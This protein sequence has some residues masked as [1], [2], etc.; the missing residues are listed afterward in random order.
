MNKLFRLCLNK[1]CLL[2]LGLFCFFFMIPP[3]AGSD[4]GMRDLA[5]SD[6]VEDELAGDIW[7]PQ[8]QI[9]VVTQD[10]IVTLQGSVDHVLAKDRATRIA[11]MVRGVR[12]VVNQIKVSPSMAYDDKEI[13]TK[14]EAALKDD[15]A[16]EDLE[17]DVKVMDGTVLLSGEVDSQSE[18]I[19]AENVTKGVRGVKAVE[20]KIGLDVPYIS[21]RPDSEIRKDIEERLRWDVLVDHGQIDVD[22]NKGTVILSGT[23]G[24]AAEKTRAILDAQV[25]GMDRID[26]S[27]LKAEKWERD[28]AFRKDKYVVKTDEEIQKA[29]QDA[30]SYDPR[31]APFQGHVDVD[32]GMVTLRGQ[33]DNL[34]AKRA[35]TRDAMN[36]VGVIAVKNRL[37]VRPGEKLPDDT[38]TD[39]VRAALRRSPHVD[40]YD[41][42]VTNRQGVV[43]V[44][45]TVDTHAQRAVASDLASG[46]KGVLMVINHITVRD[47]MPLV[48]NPYLDD[49]YAYGYTD[50]EERKTLKSDEQ[51]KESVKRELWWSPF[52]DSDDINVTVEK[53]AVTLT[54]KVD[55]WPEYQ[56]AAENAFQ[57]GATWVYNLL[58]CE[59]C[60]EGPPSASYPLE[61]WMR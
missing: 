12:G 4:A 32:S 35:A 20:N 47:D 33:V 21:Q 14:V 43:T 24:S 29:V 61:R 16:A 56:I 17:I 55:S 22:V 57:G 42:D 11:E 10:G 31:V 26:A 19:L 13:L 34:K 30:F 27:G 15:P 2:L 39:K 60:V 36:T 1:T 49:W 58:A 48:Y 46:I 59:T 37:K 9:D 50:Y 44:S 53:G 41:V 25:A 45:G 8:A 52:V 3:L 7:V 23:V 5:I 40:L 38:V 6:A 54:G 51:I 28:D 18:K